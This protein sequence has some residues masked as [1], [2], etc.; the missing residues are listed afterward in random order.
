MSPE[1]MPLSDPEPEGVARRVREILAE[2]LNLEEPP[3]PEARLIEDLGAE[4]IDVLALVFEL[5]ETFG[6][7]IDDEALA[8][9]RTV[10][11]IVDVVLRSGD[12]SEV[13]EA[14]V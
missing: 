6:G 3:P 10:G 7:S 4:S 2:V 9:I 14:T 13:G 11:D 1:E 5:E 8:R 12:S